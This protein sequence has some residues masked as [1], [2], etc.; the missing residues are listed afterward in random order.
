[1][2]ARAF[3]VHAQEPRGYEAG[4]EAL[5]TLADPSFAGGGISLG[6]RPGGSIRIVLTATPGVLRNRIAA[7][8]ELL[9]ELMLTPAKRRG[10][11]IYGLAGVAGQVGRRDAGRLVLGLGIE[12][13]PAAGSGWHLEAGLGGGV[14]IAAGWRWRWLRHN[15]T[16]MP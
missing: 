8:G 10:V 1:M 15:Q 6:L 4:I 13:A 5:A 14:R 2:A 7:R 16:R 12:G 3:P 11:G 9:A